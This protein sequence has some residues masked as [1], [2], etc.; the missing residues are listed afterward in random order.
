MSTPPPALGA[1]ASNY[2]RLS[3]NRVD[4]RSKTL[5]P[6]SGVRQR[7]GAWIL[8]RRVLSTPPGETNRRRVQ[9][10]TDYDIAAPDYPKDSRGRP[11]VNRCDPIS[12]SALHQKRTHK[13]GPRPSGGGTNPENA[14]R[15]AGE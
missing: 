14:R 5:P 9:R 8:L 11:G 6:P 3:A 1:E 4:A 7:L 12:P 2:C 15:K 13:E 10:R